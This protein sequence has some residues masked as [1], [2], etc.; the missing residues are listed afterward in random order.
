MRVR[1]FGAAN[2]QSMTGFGQLAAVDRRSGTRRTSVP[3]PTAKIRA[4]LV[5]GYNALNDLIQD[6]YLAITTLLGFRIRQGLTLRQFTIAADCLGQGC[7]L[8]DRV[9][10]LHQAFRS[11]SA[12]MDPLRRRIREPAQQFSRSIRTGVPTPTSPRTSDGRL[13]NGKIGDPSPLPW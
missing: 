2:F 8:R 4:A 6:A 7:G 13:P 12:G 11:T 10:D 5:T 1:P 9:D 3:S